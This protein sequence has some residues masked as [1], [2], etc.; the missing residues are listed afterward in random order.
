[1]SRL[2]RYF[3]LFTSG[4]VLLFSL[5]LTLPTYSQQRAIQ[6][7]AIAQI[8]QLPSLNLSSGYLQQSIALYEDEANSHY[9][10]SPTHSK[11]EFIYAR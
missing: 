11:R 2:V 8:T 4:F 6:L 1:M 7:D 5:V 9:L 10:K 3:F